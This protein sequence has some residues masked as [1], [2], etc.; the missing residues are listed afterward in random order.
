M[1]RPGAILISVS[2]GFVLLAGGTTAYAA[3]AG[4]VDGSGVIHGC[5]SNRPLNGSHLLVLQDAGTTCPN[6][7]TAISWNQT[8][9]Q[10]PQGPQGPEGQTGATGPQGQTGAT[11]PQGQTGAT[12]PQGPEG[13]SNAYLTTGDAPVSLTLPAGSYTFNATIQFSEVPPPSGDL[14]DCGLY[15]PDGTLI[16]TT[17]FVTIP[18]S[19]DTTTFAATTLV[20]ASTITAGTVTIEC[21]AE[22]GSPVAA[23]SGFTATQT[24]SLTIS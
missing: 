9:P 13:P 1:K 18:P 19:G 17:P 10:G 14:V 20:T 3:I 15:A 22:N 24:G 21:S 5:Y 4:P 6:G 12:G 23:V 16:A 2:A 7:T 11:G 8:G